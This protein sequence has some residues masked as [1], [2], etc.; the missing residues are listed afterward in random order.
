MRA[1]RSLSS[2]LKEESSVLMIEKGRTKRTN[3]RLLLP[4]ER[5]E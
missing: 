5:E 1:H 4:A 2:P 3:S